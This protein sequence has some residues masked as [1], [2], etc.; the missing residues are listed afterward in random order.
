MT[1]VSSEILIHP[2]TKDAFAQECVHHA[3]DFCTFFINR[4]RVK[5][6]DFL[7]TFGADRVSHRS[8]ILGKLRRTQGDDII[9]AF[10]GTRTRRPGLI[11]ALRHHVG[12]KFLVSKY[13]EA[14]FEA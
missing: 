9:D 7:V 8:A 2:R 14:F 12:G 1:I 13:G 5:V 6:A 3:D 10:D 11:K 4:G